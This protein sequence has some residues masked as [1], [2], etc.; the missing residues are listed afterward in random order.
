MA[1]VLFF[2]FA[3]LVVVLYASRHGE[4]VPRPRFETFQSGAGNLVLREAV[5][6]PTLQAVEGLLQPRIIQLTTRDGT[7][8]YLSLSPA[9]SDAGRSQLLTRSD[10]WEIDKALQ[11]IADKAA[12]E[13]ALPSGE[14]DRYFQMKDGLRVGYHQSGV[15]QTVFLDLGV[16]P[17]GLVYHFQDLAPLNRMISQALDHLEENR[18]T[19]QLVESPATAD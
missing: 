16:S 9:P 14:R 18:R 7:A 19:G 13:A 2:V 4:A 15:E 17:G 1:V 6:L 5:N 12:E 3:L 11:A 10:L 8:R